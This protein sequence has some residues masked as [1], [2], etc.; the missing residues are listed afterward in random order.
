MKKFIWSLVLLAGLGTL[1]P[2]VAQKA[3]TYKAFVPG[4]VWND[5]EGNPIN[6]HGGGILYHEG[7]YYWY[8]EYKKGKTVLPEWATWECYRTDVTGVSCYSSQDLMNWKFEGIVLPAVKDDA[9]HDLH[10]SKV[11]ERPK[12]I[13]NSKTGKFVMW[14]HVES[15]D[16]SK[17][18]A[19]VAVSDSPTGP[20]TYLGSFRPNNAMSRDQTVFVD[21]DGRAYQF[22]SSENNATLYI[23][24]LTDDYLRPSGRFTR[25]FIGAS[26]EAPAVFKHGGKYYMLSSGCTGWDPNQAELAVADSIMGPWKVLGNPCTGTDA[27]KTFYAQST[28]VQQV[29]GK[30]DCY[31]ALFD[32]WNKKD[33]ENSRYV[34]LPLSFESGKISIPW[35]AE[36]NLDSF[37]DQPRFEAGKGTFL[38]NGKPFIVKAAELHYPRIPKPY[39]DQRIKLCK[40]L[41][42]NTVC[43]YVFWNSHEP[44]PG[45]FD[46]T[47]QNDLAE[48]CRLCQANDM[49]V[50]LRP[51]P[52]VCAEWEMGGLPWWLLKK[53]D[54]RLRESD[55]YF[56]ERVA[57]FEKE[58]AK[59]VAGLTI[60]NGGPIIMVQVENEYGSY[61]VSKP[62]V[63][64]IRDIVR[65]N[66]GN[67]TLFQ[68]DWASNFTQNGLHDLI[69]TMNFG[70][71]ANIDQ[72]FARLK[73]LRPNSPLMCS[74]FWSGW[75]D[76]W[77][78]NHETRPADDMI[79]GIDEMLSKGISFSLYMTHG[80]TN[81]GHW[82]GA[83]SPGFAPDVTSYDYDAPISESGQTTPKYWKLRETLA[84]Y[85]N[86]EKQAKVPALIKPI[87]I[88][89]FQFTEMAPLFANLPAGKNDKDI[90]TMEDY[91]QGFGSILYRT[92]LPELKQPALLTVNDAHDYAQIFVDGNYIGKLDRRNGEKQLTL[93]ACRKGARLDI[94]VEAMG[95]INFGRAI[96]DYKGITSNV[97]LTVD[98][99]GYPFVCDLKNWEVFNIEDTYEFYKNMKFQ[100]I[101]S[102]TDENGQRIPGCYRATFQVK[103]PSDTF[104]NFETWGKGLVYVNGY[105]LG[106]I[107]EIG[108]QQTLY[109]PGCWLKK[110]ENEILVFD[111]VGPK[112]AKSEGLR[113]PLLDQLLVQKPLTHREEGQNLDL[114][115]EKPVLTGSFKPGNGWQEFKFGQPVSG[116]YLCL[117]ALNAQDGKE[118]AC[119]AEMY[120]LNADGE[121]L[122]RE[123]WIVNYADSEDV[124]HVNRSADKIFDLQESTYWSTEAGSSYP[125]A[126]VIDLGATHSLSGIQYLPRMESEVPGGIKDFKVYVR[127]EPFKY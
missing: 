101:Q 28:Y 9:S 109:V 10:P 7:T 65:Q 117:E 71:G 58:V 62:Y 14:A 74:E 53:K 45:E 115:A 23:S 75:F 83:N 44:K 52:Y 119:I 17:A 6:A 84:K 56:I 26:R 80:G 110:G 70:T 22:Y 19:G 25:N 89:A 18:C 90:R 12:V 95:R 106:R 77:G 96:K 122:S 72:Q 41:G 120:V 68:C 105:A 47:G 15:A 79:A 16:Y 114:S 50:I 38:L 3:T 82:A 85:M 11:L 13:Y 66:F 98:M 100:P 43:L 73:E 87:S 113:E 92:S 30:K 104:L 32:R 111:I 37:A 112:E 126:I 1:L 20:F 64:Q 99:N 94:L 24:E 127:T 116:R 67:V 46:F 97:E 78:A 49:Y 61:G 86:G 54:I 4:E 107:W 21:D 102:L 36:W 125:H 5:T 124:S 118:L 123:P 69:W 76:K 48:F 57:I 88:P 27:D 51:G 91:D 121:R 8:G 81:W 59:Q 35:R 40:A 2:A 33:L 63:S 34:W 39:W 55:P 42:M 93:P 31:I 29:Y 108:P 60:E 103:K